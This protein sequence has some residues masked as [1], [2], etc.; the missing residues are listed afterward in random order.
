CW[1]GCASTAARKAS[2][3]PAMPPGERAGGRR[4]S[5][6][7]R[8]ARG[9]GGGSEGGRLRGSSLRRAALLLE[10]SSQRHES[11]GEHRRGRR[12]FRR[13][14]VAV[15][16]G[17]TTVPAPAA[18]TPAAATEAAAARLAGLGLVD[19]QGAA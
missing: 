9:P 14:S 13:G 17:A 3:S 18:A 12:I 6:R 19:G 8:G 15:T 7:L 4:S 5:G 11:P 16:A 10:F 2:S 1:K